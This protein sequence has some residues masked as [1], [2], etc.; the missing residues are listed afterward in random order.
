MPWRIECLGE[1]SRMKSVLEA[2]VRRLNSRQART[3]P[4]PGRLLTTTGCPIRERCSLSRIGEQ[5]AP[6]GVQPTAYSTKGSS[7]EH[8]NLESSAGRAKPGKLSSPVM[9]RPRGGASVVVGTRESRVHG[10][11]RQSMRATPKPQGKAMYVASELDTSWL[12][13]KQRILYA[14]S[15]E[16]ITSPRLRV[17]IGGE[18]GA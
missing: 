7:R 11:G 9:T 10:E 4:E 3:R 13:S 2:S 8:G 18:P 1:P 12:L 6:P 17:N 15:A 16:G 14:R 5:S